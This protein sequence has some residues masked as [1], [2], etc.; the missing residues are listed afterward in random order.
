[1]LEAQH[2]LRA[3]AAFVEDARAYMKGQLACGPVREDVLWE[4]WV[5]PGSAQRALGAR[6][7][8]AWREVRLLETEATWESWCG[9]SL[10]LCGLGRL[11]RWVRR[12]EPG[13][14]GGRE[15]WKHRCLGG[16]SRW[17]LLVR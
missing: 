4:R 12:E 14:W 1:M 7:G 8:A 13:L 16:L 10:G 5:L 15:G 11:V 9:R 17:C 2:L 6:H 3:A